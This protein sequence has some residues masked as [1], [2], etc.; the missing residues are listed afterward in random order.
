MRIKKLCFQMGLSLL[1]VGCLMFLSGCETAK[2]FGKDM[3]DAG[4]GLQKE[5]SK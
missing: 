3:E 2:G 1:L 5:A 4:E